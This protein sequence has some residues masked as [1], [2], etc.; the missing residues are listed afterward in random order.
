MTRAWAKLEFAFGLGHTLADLTG[1]NAFD[2]V[3]EKLGEIWSMVEM[4]R[5]GVIA[6]EAGSFQAEGGRTTGSPTSARS[7]R[8][9]A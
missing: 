9:A 6:A 8:F 4:T 2:H 1:V 3:Q 5:A 7:S